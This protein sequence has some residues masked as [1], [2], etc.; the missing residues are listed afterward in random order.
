ML[1]LLIGAKATSS[2]RSTQG[3]RLRDV[4][5]LTSA[6]APPMLI[7]SDG[8]PKLI[9]RRETL[10]DDAVFCGGKLEE[11]AKASPPNHPSSP[12]FFSQRSMPRRG[13]KAAEPPPRLWRNTSKDKEIKCGQA[14]KYRFRACPHFMARFIMRPAGLPPRRLPTSRSLWNAEEVR[15]KKFSSEGSSSSIIPPKPPQRDGRRNGRRPSPHPIMGEAA[16][17]PKS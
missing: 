13:G 10:D 17:P 4:F 11:A 6:P 16:G 2:P 12:R 14:R 15:R 3:L 7:T 8:T 5:Q 9:R 1:P